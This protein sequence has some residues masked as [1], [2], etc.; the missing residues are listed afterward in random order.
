MSGGGASEQLFWLMCLENIRR[1]MNCIYREKKIFMHL[2]TED[3]LVLSMS[4][5]HDSTSK[6]TTVALLKRGIRLHYSDKTKQMLGGVCL[7]WERV[8]MRS[9]RNRK[10]EVF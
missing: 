7:H 2:S 5:L 9:C 1:I 4:L 10:E 8:D 3:P 6:R